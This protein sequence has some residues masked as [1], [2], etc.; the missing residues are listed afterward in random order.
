M[1]PNISFDKKTKKFTFNALTSIG[2]VFLLNKIIEDEID[3]NKS[4]DKVNSSIVYDRYLKAMENL[5]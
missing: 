5:K 2:D 1:R 3:K 4:I